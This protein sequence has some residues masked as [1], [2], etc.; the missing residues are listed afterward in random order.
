MLRQ[1]APFPSQ[2]SVT[3]VSDRTCLTVHVPLE[4][5]RKL[6]LLD[7]AKRN[8][9]PLLFNCE[10]GGCAACLVRVARLSEETPP[11]ALTDSEEFLLQALAHPPSKQ[12]A[13]SAAITEEL[14]LACQYVVGRGHIRVTFTQSLGAT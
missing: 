3:F 14:R 4:A 10:A 5:E 11:V 1:T 13:S 7:V 6:T 2:G 8:G 9:V 12:L